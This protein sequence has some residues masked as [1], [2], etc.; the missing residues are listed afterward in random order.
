MALIYSSALLLFEY[1]I[2]EV[3]VVHAD[4]ILLISMF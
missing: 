1:K 2:V 4:N 3:C